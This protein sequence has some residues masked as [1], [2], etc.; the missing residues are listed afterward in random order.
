MGRKDREMIANVI[1]GSAGIR[2]GENATAE[3]C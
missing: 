1:E 3:I 2:W